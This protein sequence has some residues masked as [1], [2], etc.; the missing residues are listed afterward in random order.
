MLAC[1]MAAEVKTPPKKLVDLNPSWKLTTDGEVWGLSF[2]CPCGL[3]TRSAPEHD[4][5]Y[6]HCGGRITIPT[7]QNLAGGKVA[8]QAAA[9]GWDLAG[10]SF[11]ELTLSPSIHCVGHWHGWI[12]N[13]EVLSC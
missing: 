7:R 9:I 13:G 6:C 1:G 12:R 10:K 4:E 5:G 2:D 8:A 3:P 11:A